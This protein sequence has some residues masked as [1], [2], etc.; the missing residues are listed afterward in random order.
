MQI[1]AANSQI[2]EEY[3]NPLDAPKL[4]GFNN[5]SSDQNQFGLAKRN[6]FLDDDD[7]E[8]LPPIGNSDQHKQ[9]EEKNF[10]MSSKKQF[11]E[12]ID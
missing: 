11:Y 9:E 1:Q 10:R 8:D 6:K 2:N 3:K 4:T 7:E 12:K 5:H